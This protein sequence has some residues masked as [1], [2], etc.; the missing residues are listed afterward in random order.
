MTTR[1]SKSVSLF[2]IMAAVIT[3]GFGTAGAMGLE[4]ES[5]GQ[6]DMTAFGFVSTVRP[7]CDRDFVKK[8]EDGHMLEA[9]LGERAAER[10]TSADVKQFGQMNGKEQYSCQ[11][12]TSGD[13]E[14]R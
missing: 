12:P 13:R 5:A 7:I 10:A 9:A 2:V 6:P 11:Q 1:S 3:F 8:T 4:C 14:K